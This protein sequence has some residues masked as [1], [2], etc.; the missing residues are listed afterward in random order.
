MQPL[1][2][3]GL[4]AL[5]SCV[6]LLKRFSGRYICGQRSG[7][8]MEEFCRRMCN[9]ASVLAVSYAVMVLVT[10]IPLDAARNEAPAANNRPAW[11]RPARKKRPSIARS[12]GHF[13]DC[14]SHHSSPEDFTSDAFL[15][16]RSK[17]QEPN[18]FA[19][20]NPSGQNVSHGLAQNG[21]G[22]LP[23]FMDTSG[24]MDMMSGDSSL[25]M[26]QNDILALLSD[27]SVDMTSL[28]MSPHLGGSAEPQG[29]NTFYAMT[30]TANGSG[31]V[32]MVSP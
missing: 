21:F 6:G 8:L 12:P 22:G 19:S 26:S 17:S 2:A 16:L 5:R 1:I 32:G 27:G 23:S 30:P 31:P 18:P 29:S 14:A 4:D 28:L 24:G 3:P 9:L 7:D 15:D 20:T 11:V 13:A 10:S 25:P